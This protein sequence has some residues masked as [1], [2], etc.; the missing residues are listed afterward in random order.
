MNLINP[1]EEVQKEIKKPQLTESGSF[2]VFNIQKELNFNANFTTMIHNDHL[3]TKES[4]QLFQQTHQNPS[5]IIFDA[6]L[7]ALNSEDLVPFLT[8]LIPKQNI[9]IVGC[10]DWKKEEYFFIKNNNIKIYTM[11]EISFE[12]Q[13]FVCDAIMAA[14]KDFQSLYVSIDA[15]VL[16]QTTAGLT[17]RQL[18]YF[19]QRLKNLKNFKAADLAE[20]KDHKL[21]A[22][23]LREL[24]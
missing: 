10:R 21:A 2:P 13:E 9:I 22:K 5:I 16:D 18:L 6:H 15:D 3:Q 4:F 23:I 12:G 7:D 11:K 1:S 14:A 17:P 20:F 19:L 24:A 8:S